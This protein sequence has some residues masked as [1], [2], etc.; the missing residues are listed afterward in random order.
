MNQSIT[1]HDE[2]WQVLWESHF[3]WLIGFCLLQPQFRMF[4]EDG[5]C[6]AAMSMARCSCDLIV[7]KHVDAS[8]GIFGNR[9]PRSCRIGRDF[10]W[11][12]AQLKIEQTCFTLVARFFLFP[13]H[14][15][16]TLDW[17]S[18][19]KRSKCLQ[20]RFLSLMKVQNEG[21]MTG[22][23]VDSFFSCLLGVGF[24]IEG[25]KG[26][27]RA[28]G[29][30]SKGCCTAREN[31]H[32]IVSL[33]RQAVVI[34]EMLSLTTSGKED[35]FLVRYEK[36]YSRSSYICSLVPLAHKLWWRDSRIRQCTRRWRWRWKCSWIGHTHD[37]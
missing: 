10:D 13:L 5:G 15:I 17:D 1:L 8:E 16:A 37:V 9:S 32:W 27:T 35:K 6:K 21:H 31:R 2:K 11:P 24:R 25:V 22:P 19:G 18:V 33:I 7:L 3:N 14:Q 26:R 12:T 36:A 23:I 30:L 20:V 34:V 28:H 29:Q 4:P